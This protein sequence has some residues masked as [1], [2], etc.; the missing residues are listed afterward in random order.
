M[1]R[2][3]FGKIG[4]FLFFVISGLG[5]GLIVTNFL[6][7]KVTVEGV[8]MNPTYYTGDTLI[9]NK[10]ANPDRGDIVTFHKDNKD[11][12]KRVIAISGD[13]I[14]IV[15][16][17][18]YVNGEVVEEDYIN[19]DVFSGGDIENS[20]YTLGEDEYFVMG[21]NRNNSIDSRKFGVIHREDIIGTKLFYLR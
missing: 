13:T 15:D 16:S 12:I 1:I 9:V 14:S 8:S 21:D 19:E 6:A 17:K 5:V 4:E 2:S 3:K 20:E 10:L 11:F 7:C 18:V